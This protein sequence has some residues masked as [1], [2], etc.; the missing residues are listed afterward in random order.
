MLADSIPG[1]DAFTT[2]GGNCYVAA[3]GLGDVSSALTVCQNAGGR[4][5]KLHQG[6][7]TEVIS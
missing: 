4:L 1:G 6:A 2:Y 7:F 5:A 3:R